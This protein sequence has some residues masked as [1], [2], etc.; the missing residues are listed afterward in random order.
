MGSDNFT[1]V[2]IPKRHHNFY[3]EPELERCGVKM[4]RLRSIIIFQIPKNAY[5]WRKISYTD[6]LLKCLWGRFYLRFSVKFFKK[7]KHEAKYNFTHYEGINIWAFSLLDCEFQA[8][9]TAKERAYQ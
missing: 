4:M 1:L 8:S 6:L 9:K 3:N 7:H 2:G 5:L